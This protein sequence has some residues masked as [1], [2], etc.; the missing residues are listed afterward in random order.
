MLINSK[1]YVEALKLLV[2][3]ID[4]FSFIDIGDKQGNFIEWSNSYI[5]LN[6]LQ[7][8]AEELWELRNSILHM[9]NYESRK[10]IKGEVSRL[11]LQIG[12]LSKPQPNKTFDG[13]YLNIHN[14]YLETSKAVEK[15]LTATVSDPVKMDWFFKRYDL[16]VSN[17]R[18]SIIEL[19]K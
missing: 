17:A 18:Q 12:V 13:K 5:D 19:V 11:I 1:H 4:S 8:S 6:A 3:S 15:W 2:S 9:T 10:V 14:F 7:I 16:I